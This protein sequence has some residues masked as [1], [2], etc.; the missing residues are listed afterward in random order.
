MSPV[1]KLNERV[2]RNAKKYARAVISAGR[3]TGW[4]GSVQ[5]PALWAAFLVQMVGKNAENGP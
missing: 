4:E 3:Q 5:L 2:L 1:I